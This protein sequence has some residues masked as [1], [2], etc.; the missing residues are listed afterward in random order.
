MS[1]GIRNTFSPG[2][3]T[4]RETSRV[5]ELRALAEQ[6]R[7]DDLH[8]EALTHLS[9]RPM[10]ELNGYS[11]AQQERFRQTVSE[12]HETSAQSIAR[13]IIAL[14]DKGDKATFDFLIA[15]VRTPQQLLKNIETVQKSDEQAAANAATAEVYQNGGRDPLFWVSDVAHKSNSEF[16]ALSDD[17]KPK[18][19]EYLGG[20][21]AAAIKK[22]VST[23]P[24]Y[25]ECP[26]NAAAFMAY[27]ERHGLVYCDEPTVKAIFSRLKAMGLL[28][29]KSA[30]VRPNFSGIPP[31]EAPESAPAP[32][33]R[34]EQRRAKRDWKKGDPEY[35]TDQCYV[36]KTGRYLT[37]EEFD[38]LPSAQLLSEGVRHE[39]D[40]GRE[41]PIPLTRR[42]VNAFIPAT[43]SQRVAG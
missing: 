28:R 33:T 31:V 8:N 12:Y 6:G 3:K 1:Q 36:T 43:P 14:G 32:L 22:A 11:R 10:P 17:A 42:G 16:Y 21:T 19:S 15:D 24:T 4:A 25:L 34:E 27:C 38:N 20:L 41:M 13:Q 37:T 7:F 39:N 29:E 2:V 35:L 40:L 18:R 30:E 23:H 9:A 5:P 26:E